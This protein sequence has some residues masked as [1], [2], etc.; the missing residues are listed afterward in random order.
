MNSLKSHVRSSHLKVKLFKCDIADCKASFLHKS[1][2]KRHN[3]HKHASLSENVSNT[4]DH[5][6][7]VLDEYFELPQTN[8]DGFLSVEDDFSKFI[9]A[10]QSL[11]YNL[12]IKPEEL[13][14]L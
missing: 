3:S 12:P 9:D 14:N 8:Y 2:L 5:L 10:S 6:L 11:R 13:N 1:S 4:M 7:P